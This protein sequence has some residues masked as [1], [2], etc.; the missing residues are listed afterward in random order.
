MP[1]SALFTELTNQGKM[2]KEDRKP[3]GETDSTNMQ[4]LIK[5]NVAGIASNVVL[6]WMMSKNFFAR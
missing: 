2:T 4:E 6:V 5:L 1:V 3:S